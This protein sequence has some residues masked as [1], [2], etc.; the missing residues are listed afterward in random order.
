MCAHSAREKKLDG[1]LIY[2]EVTFKDSRLIKFFKMPVTKSC[3]GCNCKVNVRK[4]VCPDPSCG[5]VS[6]ILGSG[7]K[8][9]SG[10]QT[11]PTLPKD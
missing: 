6:L 11:P 10:P 8:L 3:P 5:H 1:G 9:C 7:G 2:Y 4:L